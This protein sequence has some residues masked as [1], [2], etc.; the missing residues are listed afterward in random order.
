MQ[1]LDEGDAGLER[2]RHAVARRDGAEVQRGG[3]R[4]PRAA[5]ARGRS[6][7]VR[8][9]DGDAVGPAPGR[10]GEPVPEVHR[11]ARLDVAAP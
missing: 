10:A 6:A 9:L 11:A 1:R 8:R 5:A 7:A 2:E 4:A 3:A